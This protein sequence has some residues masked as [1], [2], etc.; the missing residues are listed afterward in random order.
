M[1]STTKSHSVVGGPLS[2][3]G[4]PGQSSS[5][6]LTS[7]V[8]RRPG[9][10]V[11]GPGATT[12]TGLAP[13]MLLPQQRQQQWQQQWQQVRSMFIQTQKTPN[14]NALQF[15]PGRTVLEEEWGTG[16][17]FTSYAEAQQSGL[18]KRLFQ[19][20][21]VTN[22]FLGRDFV[23]INLD[24]VKTD[25]HLAKPHIFA[26]LMD[27]FAQTD[28]P[29]MSAEATGSSD[30][31]VEDDD[32]EVVAMIKELIE[33]RIRPSVQEDGGDIYF[34][35]FDEDTGVVYLELAGSCAGCPSSEVTLKHGVENMLKY[36]VPEVTSIMAVEQPGV[37][38]DDEQAVADYD[39]KLS[40]NPQS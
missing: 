27:F 20:D 1:R 13:A 5:R 11:A 23:T 17:N 19:L 37:N 35:K 33:M 39:R 15:L 30:T 8:G 4:M 26:V 40:F 18:A 9:L 7:A 31:R 3:P 32:T 12:T 36:Y 22:V 10:R 16:V 29:V 6:A 28:V 2:M 38:V 25:W 34:R 24:T 14:P 21:G